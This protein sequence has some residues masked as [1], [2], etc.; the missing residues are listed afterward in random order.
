MIGATHVGEVLAFDEARGI[1]TVRAEDGAT[2]GFHCTQIADGSRTIRVGTRVRYE[3]A[4]S[5]LGVW[6]ATGLDR[7]A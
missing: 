1:G 3:L 4:A 7:V 2:L 6:E 5:P